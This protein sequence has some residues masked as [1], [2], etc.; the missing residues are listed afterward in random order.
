MAGWNGEIRD[1]SGRTKSTFANVSL[2]DVKAKVIARK[3]GEFVTFTHPIDPPK[4]EI[5]ELVRMGTRKTL[6]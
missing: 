4:S 6:P 1:E 3:P 2:T 5:E